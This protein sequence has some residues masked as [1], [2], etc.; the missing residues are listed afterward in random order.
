MKR[1]QKE[2]NRLEIWTKIVYIDQVDDKQERRMKRECIVVET[3]MKMT[4]EEGIEM[5]GMQLN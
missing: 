2:Q 3:R 4:E 1:V 5:D